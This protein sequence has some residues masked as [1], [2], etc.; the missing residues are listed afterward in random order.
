MFAA[1]KMT[2]KDNASHQASQSTPPAISPKPPAADSDAAADSSTQIPRNRQ[3]PPPAPFPPRHLG[4]NYIDIFFNQANPQTPILHRPSFEHIFQRACAKIEAEGG[5]GLP[6]DFS[7]GAAGGGGGGGGGGSVGTGNCAERG[8]Q[9][10][11]DLYFLYM[12]FAIATAMSSRTE[13]LPERYHASAML[14]MDSLFS[15]ISRTNNRLDGLKGILLLALYSIMRPAAPGVWYV[16]GAAMRL[17]IDLGLHQENTAKAEK[18]WDPLTLD[19][20]RRLW[21]CTYCLDRQICVYLGR[22][23]GIADEAIKTPFPVDELEGWSEA[24]QV[25]PTS[26]DKRIKSCRTV[27]IHIF[28]IR[29]IQSEIQQV[30]YQSSSALPRKFATVEEWRKD[31]EARL[32][33]WCDSVPK[34]R[35]DMNNCGYNLSF[36][37]L[38]YQQTRLLLYGLCPAV[39]TPSTEAFEVIADSGSRIIRLYRQLH[40]EKSINYTWLAC[41]NL[42]MAGTSYLCALWH[43]HEVRQKTNAEEIDFNNLACVDV[44]SSMTDKCPAAQGCRDVFE[45]LASATVQLCTREYA[46]DRSSKR[47]KLEYQHPQQRDM[48]QLPEHEINAVK[49]LPAS[50]ANILHVPSPPPAYQPPTYADAEILMPPHQ[51]SSTYQQQ[52]YQH[53]LTPMEIMDIMDGRGLFEMMQEVGAIH[54]AGMSWDGNPVASAVGVQYTGGAAGMGLVGGVGGSGEFFGSW[55]V[56]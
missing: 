33:L 7:G 29:Q 20:R 24:P 6:A 51:Q 35:E 22:P 12:V 32:K 5:N 45:S 4:E 3:R 31:V 39:P 53:M 44:L 49:N 43:S 23:F 42:F 25:N 16:L 36:I 13:T 18:M 28:R 54:G 26:G 37:D 56:F 40:R 41:H 1:V 55:S 52:L 46:Q 17:A 38:N 15:S 8:H 14:H 11:A 19:E 50:L 34:S 9:H 47:V 21:W 10:C 30:L 2:N 27:S 48:Y